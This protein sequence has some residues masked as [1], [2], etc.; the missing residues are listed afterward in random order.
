MFA[1]AVAATTAAVQL[2][3]LGPDATKAVAQPFDLCSRA[4]MVVAQPFD[5]CPR[6]RMVAALVCCNL[7]LAVL[8]LLTVNAFLI[9]EM[10]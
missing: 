1:K 4:R 7:E 5:L 6:A 8:L 2:P 3:A 9:S 10:E